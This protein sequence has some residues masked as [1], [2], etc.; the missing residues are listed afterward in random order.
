MNEKRASKKIKTAP[1][2]IPMA[3]SSSNESSIDGVAV[4]EEEM[5]LVVDIVDVEVDVV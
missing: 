2:V 3:M 4:V 1:P 5:P